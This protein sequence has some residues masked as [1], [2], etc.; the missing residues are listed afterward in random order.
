MNDGGDQGVAKNLIFGLKND[1][2]WGC[3]HYGKF[4]IN[5]KTA[6]IGL[7]AAS[8]KDRITASFKF[9]GERKETNK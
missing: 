2:H 7:K 3:I 4:K 6:D 9:I 1:A 5:N 8:S